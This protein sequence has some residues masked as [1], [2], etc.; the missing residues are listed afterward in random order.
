M[1]GYKLQQ[2]TVLF[3]I[4]RSDKH[5]REIIMVLGVSIIT[6]SYPATKL[7]YPAITVCR[8]IPY[9]PDE[10]VRAVFDNFQLTCNNSCMDYCDAS[11]E[12]TEVLREDFEAYIDWN[13]VRNL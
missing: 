8:K 13:Y 9:N 4:N 1:I 3:I 6:F 5:G 11:C 7:N 10:Y 2:V 12:E